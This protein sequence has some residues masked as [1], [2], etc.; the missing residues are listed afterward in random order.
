VRY[1]FQKSLTPLNGIFNW[2][3][4]YRRD[5]DILASHAMYYPTSTRWVHLIW[6]TVR[7]PK[8]FF[9]NNQAK[10]FLKLL[11]TLWQAQIVCDK[12]SFYSVP[13]GNLLLRF[14]YNF[15]KTLVGNVSVDFSAMHVKCEHH[16]FFIN[17]G[18]EIHSLS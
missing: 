9:E 14:P 10:R 8:L 1:V 7:L 3:M 4:T 2:T 16:R 12:G 6:H 15:C 5:S 11:S 17:K 13:S 18:K